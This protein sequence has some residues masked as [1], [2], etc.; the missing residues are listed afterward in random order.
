MSN[1]F[2]RQQ[3]EQTVEETLIVLRQQNDV[4]KGLGT[5][6]YIPNIDEVCERLEPTAPAWPKGKDAYRS[7]RIRFGEGHN[8]MIQTFEAH[9]AAIKRV[10]AKFWRWDLLLSG[11]HPYQDK[12]VDR[13][14]LLA[15]NE[16]HH[17]VVEWV[18]IDDL[19]ANRKRKD[20]TSV[21]GSQSLA[22][23]GLVLAWLFPKRVDAIDYD[24][25]SAW[26]C[27]GYE[28]SVPGHDDGPWRRV[29]CVHRC[30]YD[31]ATGLDAGWRSFDYSGC[32]VP[33]LRE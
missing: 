23:E 30:L 9:A 24:K 4:W 26:F 12:Q 2:L 15:G 19:S 31:G 6:P 17:A 1:V 25:W 32:S 18:T 21:R 20:V 16:T 28:L 14:R 3:F 29:P 27:A 22:D 11:E 13:L 7:L 5:H 10:H 8:G 33:P